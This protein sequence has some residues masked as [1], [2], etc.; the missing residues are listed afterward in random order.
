MATYKKPGSLAV[1]QFIDKP[2]QFHF[3]V[4]NIDEAPTKQDGSSIDAIKLDL[5]VQGG[6]DETQIKKA[7]SPLLFNPSESHRDGGEFS[8]KVH[9]RLADACG[10]LPKAEAD[11]EVEIDW[12]KAR[13]RQI[14]AFVK[15]GKKKE[16]EEPRLEIDGAHIYH[17][18]DPEAK[19]VPTNKAV[20]AL[21]PASLRRISTDPHDARN[22][23]PVANGN[24]KA[25]NGAAA[26]G[27]ASSVNKPASGAAK[28]A[29][30]SQ[31]APT[32]PAND[33]VVDLDN[34]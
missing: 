13:G 29:A 12:S 7:F 4:N 10:L 18:D 9:L 19:H 31:A 32:P 25:A 14:I 8:T 3:L 22:Q 24:G 27:A 6:T 21:L 15:F 34:V 2:G 26:N 1:T 5:T 30:K 17:V 28:A 33:E 23:K 20:L 11:E 16:G